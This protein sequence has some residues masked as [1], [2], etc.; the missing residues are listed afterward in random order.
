MIDAR[1][2]PAERDTGDGLA[3]Y[4]LQIGTPLQPAL[5]R[6]E[7][8]QAREN[9]VRELLKALVSFAADF[10]PSRTELAELR[11]RTL[12]G[13]PAERSRALDE[14]AAAVLAI[15]GTQAAARCEFGTLDDSDELGLCPSCRAD[16]EAWRAAKR[17]AAT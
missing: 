3:V 15:A 7:G 17:E 8:Q 14:H 13:S 9:V 6:A 12:I 16:F 11:G 5:F 2:E 10:A 1:N 4:R